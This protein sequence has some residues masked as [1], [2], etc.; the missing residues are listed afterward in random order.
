M[1]IHR[2]GSGMQYVNCTKQLVFLPLNSGETIHLAPGELSRQLEA[3]E[4]DR[5]AKLERLVK[6]GVVRAVAES[7]PGQ[8]SS[9]S[10]SS[11]NP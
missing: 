7:K 1:G 4:T 10:P 2:N 8:T 5:N 11:E 9:K 6:L 3:Y